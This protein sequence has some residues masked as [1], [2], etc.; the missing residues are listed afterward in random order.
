MTERVI[1]KWIL[2]GF[3]DNEMANIGKIL[4]LKVPGFRQ[5]NP[6][7]KNFKILRPK[8]IYEALVPKNA[9]KLKRFFNTATEENADNL[10][11]R[12]KNQEDLLLAIGKE[13]APSVLFTALL[14]SSEE[15]DVR[16]A[17]EIYAK[18]EAEGK[19][20]QM[21]KLAEE[22]LEDADT[23]DGKEDQKWTESQEELKEAQQKV[24]S[25]EKKLKKSEQKNENLKAQINSVQLDFDT[26]RKEW[27]EEKK[28]LIKEIQMLSSEN[29]KLNSEAEAAHVEIATIN[30]KYEQQQVVTKRKD[31][32]ISRLNALILKLKTNSTRE[33]RQ[34]ESS[35]AKAA[36]AAQQE[37]DATP[38]AEENKMQVAVIGDPKNSRVQR[39]KKFNLNI[40]EA[41]EIE[42][43]RNKNILDSVNRIWLLTYKTPRGAQKRIKSMLKGKEILEFA[44]FIDLENHMKKG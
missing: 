2:D 38:V 12:G 20:E 41:S 43:E 39:Y 28:K 36:G 11:Y 44:T 22:D 13:I 4:E 33:E 17:I 21:E 34:A 25:C 35:K 32:E 10:E 7:I 8:L 29:S 37:I 31:E 18:L 26:E 27:K 30:K 15:M 5:I 9:S 19:L 23:T 16:N 40:I 14:S 6:K 24:I 3:S 42:E 1:W